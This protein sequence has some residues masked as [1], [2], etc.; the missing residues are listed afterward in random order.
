MP[1]VDHL[2]EIAFDTR[3]RVR[4]LFSI[5]KLCHAIADSTVESP[6]RRSSWAAA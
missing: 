2:D 1:L 3:F 5:E 4:A 6:L